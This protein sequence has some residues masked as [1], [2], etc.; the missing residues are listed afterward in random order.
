[1]RIIKATEYGRIP[2]SIDQNFEIREDIVKAGYVEVR[3]SSEPRGTGGSQLLGLNLAAYAKGWIGLIPLNDAEAVC[4]E[5][6]FPIEIDRM[7]QYVDYKRRQVEATREYGRSASLTISAWMT[8]HLTIFALEHAIQI[9]A[10]GLHREYVP[11]LENTST[12]TGKI[13]FGETLRNHLSRNVSTRLTT[14]Y[15]YR[16]D[17]TPT[18]WH[19]RKAIEFLLSAETQSRSLKAPIDRELRSL[20]LRETKHLSDPSR[21]AR[22]FDYVELLGERDF[23]SYHLYRN[24]FQAVELLKEGGAISFQQFEQIIDLPS[25]LVKTDDIFEKF[26]LAALQV[27]DRTDSIEVLD[28]NDLNPR[29]RLFQ[30]ADEKDFCGGKMQPLG[31]NIIKPDILI[32]RRGKTE[33]VI[34]VK[35][36]KVKGHHADRSS[37]IEQLVTFAHRLDC[38]RAVSIHP[39]A[40]GQQS[41]LYVSGR[42][43]ETIIYYYLINL[44]SDTFDEELTKLRSAVFRDLLSVSLP[45]D[46]KELASQSS[47]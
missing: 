4:I 26:V 46:S 23:D 21:R 15:Y 30:S 47:A 27:L 2:L 17:I 33:L 39:M 14:E 11:I 42:I 38:K 24:F 13:R 43:G 12:P 20:L 35:Y 10:V 28:G 8:E 44:S 7:L 18:N 25:T 29:R 37:V 45:I 36:K 3:N 6:R 5:P 31:E 1:M 19:F 16:T 34:D 32:E 22:K 41:G 40:V 9:L